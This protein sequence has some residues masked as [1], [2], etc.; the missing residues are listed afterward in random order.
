M[1]SEITDDEDFEG[2][3]DWNT[4]GSGYEGSGEIIENYSTDTTSD[5]DSEF[6]PN[7]GDIDPVTWVI[8]R[9]LMSIF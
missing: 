4:E 5:K 7:L 9:E 8:D 1:R 3:G 2:S 6:L